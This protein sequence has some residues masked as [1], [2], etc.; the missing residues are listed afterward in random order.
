MTANSNPNQEKKFDASVAEDAHVAVE[1]MFIQMFNISVR[2]NFELIDKNNLPTG[3]V[4]GMIGLQKIPRG[5]FVIV[6]PAATLFGLLKNLYGKDFNEIDK[7]ALAM[8]GEI[9]NIVYGILKA[10]LNP[11]GFSLGFGI[12]QVSIGASPRIPKA[13]WALCG[14]FESDIGPFQFLILQI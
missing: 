4:T 11:K 5:A 12:P 6:M 2:S 14:N 1:K 8:V 7:P 9:T 13:N 10:R 3:D